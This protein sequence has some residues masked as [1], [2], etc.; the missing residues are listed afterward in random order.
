MKTTGRFQTFALAAVV[1][2]AGVAIGSASAVA[3]PIS[4]HGGSGGSGGAQG[5]GSHGKKSKKKRGP[6]HRASDTHIT[7]AT[8]MQ[9]G[10]GSIDAALVLT[11]DNPRCAQFL[12]GE[13]AGISTLPRLKDLINPRLSPPFNQVGSYGGVMQKTAVGQYAFHLPADQL[14]LSPLDGHVH[15]LKDVGVDV[16]LANLQAI[17]QLG[18]VRYTKN[19]RKVFLRCNYSHQGDTIA[20]PPLVTTDLWSYGWPDGGW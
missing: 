20:S 2:Y 12:P 10:D 15:P 14:V 18:N 17:V 7:L 3:A 4:S 9:N 11:P 6:I 16:T 19:G 8:T 13:T 5:T 1:L